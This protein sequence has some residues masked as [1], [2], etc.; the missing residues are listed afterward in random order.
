MLV[1]LNALTWTH[2]PEALAADIREAQR[3][4]VHLLPCHEFPSVLD[5]GSARAALDFKAII[6]ATPEGLKKAPTNIYSEIAIGLKSGQ[7]REPGLLRLAAALI[8]RV[9]RA[10]I[11]AARKGSDN[12]SGIIPMLSRTFSTVDSTRISVGNARSS[13]RSNR[14]SLGVEPNSVQCDWKMTESTSLRQLSGTGSNLRTSAC[15]G[16]DAAAAGAGT[17]IGIEMGVPSAH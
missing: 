16:A 9:P 17:G 6:D 11:A 10:P 3:L 14:N 2:D 1:Y 13:A 8:K 4:G 12:F 5:A 15:R 7:L